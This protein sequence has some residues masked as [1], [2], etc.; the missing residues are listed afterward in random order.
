MSGCNILFFQIPG[1][2]TRAELDVDTVLL[3]GE[4]FARYAQEGICLEEGLWLF[5]MKSPEGAYARDWYAGA[6][7]TLRLYDADGELFLEK[8]GVLSEPI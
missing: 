2:T 5:S 6:S 4:R 3:G 1:E 8:D 7:Y